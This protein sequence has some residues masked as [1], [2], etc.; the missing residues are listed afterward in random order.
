MD[1]LILSCSKTK[2]K[3]A[4]PAI[5]VYD[6]RL[7]NIIKSR[8]PCVAL[9]ILSAEY[10]LIEPIDI[11]KPY[12]KTINDRSWSD[13][14]LVWQWR[15]LDLDTYP[16]VYVLM[17]QDYV[18]ALADAIYDEVKRDD[19]IIRLGSGSQGIGQMQSVL[20]DFCQKQQEGEPPFWHQV[21]QKHRSIKL[22]T[23]PLNEVVHEQ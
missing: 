6:G 13:E 14:F 19:Q 11:I 12:D 10:G 3:T 23:R 7:F 20:V 21:V 4:G 22:K 16:K 15:I 1:A 2:S 9:F 8:L 18:L 17:G 5:Q